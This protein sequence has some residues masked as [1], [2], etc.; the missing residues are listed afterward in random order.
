M[1][2]PVPTGINPRW[3]YW[4]LAAGITC[5]VT[6]R[7]HE[8]MAWI[9]SRWSEWRALRG[10]PRDYSARR[11]DHA[12]FDAWLPGRVEELRAQRLAQEPTP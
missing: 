6:G 3:A 12:D 10:K 11:E 9:S 2:I 7:N 8:Y 4:C 5:D 1:S